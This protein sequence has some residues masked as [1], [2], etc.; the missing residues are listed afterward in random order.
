MRIR[1][2]IESVNVN[3]TRISNR[4][5]KDSRF[6]AYAATQWH[7]LYLPYVPMATGML[8]NTVV[9]SP[10]QIVHTVPYARYQYNGKRHNFRR[11]LHPKASAQWDRKAQPTQLPKLISTLQAYVNRGGIDFND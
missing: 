11:D 3:P 7:R 4:I 1:F 10:G 8:A 9:I 5:M 2:E 6:W